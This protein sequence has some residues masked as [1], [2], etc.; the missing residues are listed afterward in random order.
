MDRL[1][2]A[3]AFPTKIIKTGGVS[4]KSINGTNHLAVEPP[5]FSYPR[6]IQKTLGSG[7]SSG[8]TPGSPDYVDDLKGA[9]SG[10]LKPGR[11]EGQ[12]SFL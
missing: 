5:L 12:F 8:K 4:C 3:A 11:V 10:E 6:C 2:F 7:T 9:L 1:S